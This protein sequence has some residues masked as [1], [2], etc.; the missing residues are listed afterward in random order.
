M[1]AV[2]VL[3]AGFESFHIGHVMMIHYAS[4]LS[5]EQEKRN[6]E[7]REKKGRGETRGSGYEKVER[8][9]KKE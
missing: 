6:E 2:R 4:V 8:V 3:F 7:M 1:K 5:R 9:L